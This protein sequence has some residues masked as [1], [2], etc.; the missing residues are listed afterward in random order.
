MRT[1]KRGL[2]LLL[3]LVLCLGVLPGTVWAERPDDSEDPEEAEYN[4]LPPTESGIQTTSSDFNI[5]DRGVNFICAREGYHSTCYQDN[6]QSSIGYG[7]KC[8]GSSEQPH[9][10]GSHSITQDAALAEMKSQINSKYAPRVRNQTAGIEMNQN[11]FDAL[12]SLCYNCGGGTNLIANSPLVK[13]LK[14]ELTETEARAAYSNYIV[15][16]GGQV[17]QGLINR[18]N[19]EA[20]LFFE[21]TNSTLT[22]TEFANKIATLKTKYREGE[23]WSSNNG[24]LDGTGV[25]PCNNDGSQNGGSCGCFRYNGT[26]YAGQCYGYALQMAYLIFGSNYAINQSTWER[27]YTVSDLYAGDHVRLGSQT[28]SIFIVK[29]EGDTVTYTDCNSPN[30]CVVHWNRTKSKSSLISTINGNSNNFVEHLKGSTLRGT[31]T[32]PPFDVEISVSTTRASSHTLPQSATSFPKGTSVYINGSI[33]NITVTDVIFYITEPGGSEHEVCADHGVSYKSYFWMGSGQGTNGYT[34]SKVGTYHYRIRLYS[35][36][37]YKDFSNTIISTA[38]FSFAMNSNGGSGNMSG[39]TVNFGNN[40]TIPANTFT[41]QGYTFTGWNVRRDKDNKWHVPGGWYT[42]SEIASNGYTKSLYP[43]KKQLTFDDSWTNGYDGVSSYTFFAIWAVIHVSGVTLDKTSLTLNQGA[44]E[45]LTATVAP[46]NALDKSVTWSSSNTSVATVSNGKVT[47]VG[48][49]TATIT[50]KTNDGGKTA[51]C[52]V[53][54]KAMYLL[55]LQG[56]LD[57]VDYNSLGSF[58]TADV[59]VNGTRV[60]DDV[61]DYCTQWPAGTTYEIKDIKAKSGYTYLGRTSAGSLSGTITGNTYIFPAFETYHG[62]TGVTLNKTYLGLWRFAGPKSEQ[63]I[64]TVS[65]SNATNKNVTWTSSNSSIAKVDSNGTVTA[66]STGQAVITV[67]TVDGGKT[68]SCNVTV[69]ATLNVNGFY[70]GTERSNTSGLGT[71]DLYI[72]SALVADDTTDWFQEFANGTKYEIKDVRPAA[73]YIFVGAKA[74]ND[75]LTG[76]V[77]TT[78]NVEIILEFQKAGTYTI[79][80]DANGGTGAPAAQTKTQGQP[81]TISGTRPTR[82]GYTFLGWAENASATAAQYQPNG[83]FTKDANTTLYAVWEINPYTITTDG[84]GGSGNPTTFSV[85]YGEAFNYPTNTFTNPGYSFTGWTLRRDADGKWYSMDGGWLT[86]EEIASTEYSK[87]LYQENGND[88]LSVYWIMGYSGVT[89]FTF[90]AQWQKNAPVTYT[91]TYDA[92]GGTGAPAAQTKTQGQPLTLS[93]TRPIREGYTFLGWAENASVTAAQYQPNEQFTKDANTTLYAVWAAASS[94][95]P[96]LSLDSV[97]A[98]PGGSVTLNVK[99]SKPTTLKSILFDQ[100]VYDHSAL[101]L[102]GGEWK[103]NDAIIANWDGGEQIASAAFSHNVQLSGTIFSMTFRINDDAEGDYSISFTPAINVQS[104][105]Q[106]TSVS[107]LFQ[108]GVITVSAF[109]R[110]DTNGDGYVTS[111]DAIYL[112]RH[113]LSPTRYPINQSGDMNGDGYITSDDAIYLLR[114]TLSPS[115]YPLH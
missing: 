5:S 30:N 40:F 51:S 11:Q 100:F 76:T 68:A 4:S 92:N 85:T 60:A 56:N 112:L 42:E 46:S 61:S 79:T 109:Q 44:S 104:G 70:D 64:A 27:K 16:S 39:F 22:E 71:F 111:D 114:H 97:T 25:H 88:Y 6:T 41:R 65:P 54:V 72:N 99:L 90:F 58:G 59:Y 66:V 110:G 82:E 37:Y 108:P 115:R 36:S 67:T 28:H 84:N 12:V 31:S 80:Y 7:T 74:G 8:T 89:S 48:A 98:S 24:T 95:L 32:P 57:G 96:T 18:R 19:A 23:Y 14:G 91:I 63:L 17:S 47:A 69:P 20:D 34:L 73:G 13:Y 103:L 86:E 2:A 106:E 3:C 49:G 10:A 50:V 93:S 15:Y 52:N 62:V 53:T 113:T 35:G 78:N 105:S 38:S 21:T 83:Q 55:D 102:T 29:V 9:A 1:W 77:G 75:G 87:A 94:D 107:L 43:D 26:W 101:T 45:T 81:L 33:S